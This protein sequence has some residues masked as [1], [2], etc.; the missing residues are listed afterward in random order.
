MKIPDDL[1]MTRWDFVD[2]TYGIPKVRLM[3]H[4]DDQ[5]RWLALTLDESL[6]CEGATPDN[7]LEA[8]REALGTQDI[9]IVD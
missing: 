4:P 7:A 9:T 3:N 2:V 5:T 8:L 1:D 6:V